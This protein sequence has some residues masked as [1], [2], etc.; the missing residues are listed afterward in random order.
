MPQ[1]KMVAISACS[2][3]GRSAKK[4]SIPVSS[5]SFIA[6]YAE[7]EKRVILYL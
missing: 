2:K 7:K 1:V 6:S 4:E 3:W 5:S